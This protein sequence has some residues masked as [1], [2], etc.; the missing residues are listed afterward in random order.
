MITY[1]YLEHRLCVVNIILYKHVRQPHIIIYSICN[2][3]VLLR[4]YRSVVLTKADI[5]ILY[6]LKRQL[7]LPKRKTP[8][9]S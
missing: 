5:L 9:L 3:D 6:L 2:Y 7:Q 4:F 8:Q 1:I